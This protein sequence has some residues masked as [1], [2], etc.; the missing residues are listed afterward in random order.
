MN[1]PKEQLTMRRAVA[2]GIISGWLS[3]SW[4]N[5]P[6]AE[7]R[8]LIEYGIARGWV[9]PHQPPRM[10]GPAALGL[11]FK[12]TR[13]YYRLYRKLHREALKG[14]ARE[15]MRKFRERQRQRK[16]RG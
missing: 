10:P 2:F 3:P 7:F 11:K 15:Y 12:S 14:K 8:W 4:L 5:D 13:D 1:T 6:H 9:R 16:I